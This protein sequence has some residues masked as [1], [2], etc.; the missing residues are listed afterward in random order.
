[1]ISDIT[2]TVYD[3]YSFL[4]LFQIAVCFAHLGSY[5]ISTP[6]MRTMQTMPNII[7]IIISN[8]P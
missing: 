2:D 6:V 7:Y 1:M 3:I 8:T 5:D 4:E